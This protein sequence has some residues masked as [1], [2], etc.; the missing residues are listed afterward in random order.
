M[1]PRDIDLSMMDAYTVLM[2]F[3]MVRS[4]AGYEV[5][6]DGRIKDVIKEVDE[7]MAMKQ[8]LEMNFSYYKEYAEKCGVDPNQVFI[9]TLAQKLK[10]LLPEA[11]NDPGNGRLLTMNYNV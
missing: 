5:Y 11:V 6:S 4:T 1:G 8:V 7:K 2:A 10:E 3:G 9:G